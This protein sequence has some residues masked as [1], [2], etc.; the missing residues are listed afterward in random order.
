MKKTFQIAVGLAVV[1]AL[2]L[3]AVALAASKTKVSIDDKGDGFGGYVH[4][5]KPRCENRRVRLYKVKGHKPKPRKDRKLGSDLAQPNGPDSQYFIA[6]DATSGR[7][8]TYVKAKRGC[9]AARSK[10]VKR[11]PSSEGDGEG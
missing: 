4:S 10:V 7:F 9:K 3:S 5:K 6:N 11:E 1:L 2:S 8:Y